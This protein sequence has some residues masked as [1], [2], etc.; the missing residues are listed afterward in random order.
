[1]PNFKVSTPHFNSTLTSTHTEW[2][3]HLFR[4]TPKLSTHFGSDY[5]GGKLFF[6]NSY[7]SHYSDMSARQYA[8][9]SAAIYKNK[10]F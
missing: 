5:E 2:N 6:Q 7:Y 4:Q 3:L 8:F 1:M 9:L 10:S